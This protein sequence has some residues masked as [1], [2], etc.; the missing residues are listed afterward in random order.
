AL[1]LLGGAKWW[2]N[3]DTLYQSRLYRPLATR[4]SIS[5]ERARAELRFEIVDSIL[6]VFPLDRLV[7]EH[8][9][10]MHLFV[11]DSAHS[12]AF[13]H[14]HPIFDGK[15]TFSTAIPPLPPGPSQLFADTT[16][17]TGRT[18]TP[19]PPAAQ[20]RAEPPPAAAA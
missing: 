15:A 3:V 14:L 9:K 7:P 4:A 2:K 10:L 19:T 8:G 12:T 18:R 1:L 17:E 16:L 11:V 20:T 13:A 5:H 6:R